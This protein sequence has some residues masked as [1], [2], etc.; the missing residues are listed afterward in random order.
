MISSTWKP[1]CPVG[2][3]DLS[4]VTVTHWGFNHRVHTGHLV[5][6]RDVAKHVVGLFKEMFS[7]KFPMQYVGLAS[8]FGGD[9]ER[10]MSQNVTSAFNCRPVTG[11]EGVFSNHSYGIALDINPVQNPY[12]KGSTVLPESGKEYVIRDKSRPGTITIDSFVYKAF[13]KQGWTWGGDWHS[14][15]D[16][17]HFENTATKSR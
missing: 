10:M 9:D 5:V 2:L 15:K 16:Y 1:E 7:Q 3:D 14:L 6:H 8:D 4:Y 17:Q 11:R 12:V 13:R